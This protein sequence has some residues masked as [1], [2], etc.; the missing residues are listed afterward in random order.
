VSSK[1][2]ELNASFFLRIIFK[3]MNKCCG[4]ALSQSGTPIIIGTTRLDMKI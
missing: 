3:S 1:L 2:S 4:I